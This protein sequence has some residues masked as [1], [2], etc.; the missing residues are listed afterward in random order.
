MQKLC[1]KCGLLFDYPASE[2]CWCKSIADWKGVRLAYANCLC[3]SC[4]SLSFY[5]PSALK[6]VWG[7]PS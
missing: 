1:A 5:H 3:K 2:D 4:L 6:R 7:L